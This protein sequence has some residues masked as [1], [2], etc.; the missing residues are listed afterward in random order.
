MAS[1][2]RTQWHFIFLARPRLLT[3]WHLCTAQSDDPSNAIPFYRYQ[4]GAFASEEVH[5]HVILSPAPRV[6]CLDSKGRPLTG[7]EP[8]LPFSPASTVT[9]NPALQL[10][11][12]GLTVAAPPPL[13]LESPA[14]ER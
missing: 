11:G 2:T 14:A 10:P 7:G 8:V 9:P 1:V 13:L 3:V 5:C 12:E 6:A 4:G